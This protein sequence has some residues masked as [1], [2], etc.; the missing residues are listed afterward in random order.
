MATAQRIVLVVLASR[1][2]L[3]E[4]IGSFKTSGREANKAMANKGKFTNQLV[5][6]L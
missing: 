2:L 4:T 5:L 1:G 6:D 3:A